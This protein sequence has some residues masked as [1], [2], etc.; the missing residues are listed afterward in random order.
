MRNTNI[1]LTAEQEWTVNDMRLGDLD[2]L[3]AD[4]QMLPHNGDII[5]SEEVE[6][7]IVNTP[8]I[9]AVLVPCKIG[10][11]VYGIRHYNGKRTVQKGFVSEMFFTKDM[12]LMIVVKHVCR[13]F[14]LDRVFPTYDTAAAAELESR[15]QQ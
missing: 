15:W 2:A 3:W 9:D 14:W 8:T 12:K 5:S 10:D 1:A 11:V 6:Q 7:E 13:G 4:I